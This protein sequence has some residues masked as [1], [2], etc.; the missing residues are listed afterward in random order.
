MST[1]TPTLSDAS[2][3]A[4]Q[5]TGSLPHDNLGPAIIAGSVLCLIFA[6]AFLSLRIWRSFHIK[7]FRWEDGFLIAS[8][9]LL[10]ATV[11]I[12]IASVPFGQGRHVWDIPDRNN[13]RNASRL[14]VTAIAIDK[15]ALAVAKVSV[16]ITL[17]QLGLGRTCNAIII[18]ATLVGALGNLLVV[19]DLLAGCNT[20]WLFHETHTSYCLPLSMFKWTTIFR[21]AA[22]A[23]QDVVFVLAPIWFLRYVKITRRDRRAI[24]I[25]LCFLLAA[26]VFAIAKAIMIPAGM[27]AIEDITW[28]SANV[29]CLD[30]AETAL[31]IMAACLPAVRQVLTRH[32]P[33]KWQFW[34]RTGGNTGQNH[35]TAESSTFSRIFLRRHGGRK[36]LLP[37]H[38]SDM[39]S[40]DSLKMPPPLSSLSASGWKK[41]HSPIKT[42]TV[43][44][45]SAAGE[46]LLTLQ[47]PSAVVFLR[48]RSD[49]DHRLTEPFSPLSLDELN[50]TDRHSTTPELMGPEISQLSMH[51]DDVASSAGSTERLSFGM[52]WHEGLKVLPNKK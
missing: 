18:F 31:S 39:R 5:Q 24:N 52:D 3:P 35:S 10:A 44:N 23:F 16:C 32:L 49:S 41:I 45:I 22:N 9:V 48:P 8:T 7:R 11:G 43:T 15:I 34:K 46:S 40:D 21:G 26:T 13:I 27:A 51:G 38:S 42:E 33:Q 36:S 20:Y 1:S 28:R 19:I 17:V 14:T 2:P 47:A 4:S 30:P 37:F 25:M 6:A 50:S 29:H 12:I